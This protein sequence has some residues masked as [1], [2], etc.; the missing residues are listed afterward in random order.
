MEPEWL[1]KLASSSVDERRRRIE[2][3]HPAIPITR[4]CELLGLTR[5]SCYDR[6]EPKDDEN[7]RLM[8]LI[9]GTHLAH[10]A[11]GSRQMTRWLRR[12]RNR[13]TA[14]GCAG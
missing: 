5:A 1:K 9:D 10:P 8:K 11:F 2:Q 14:S 12:K 7:L 4:Q 6:P 13:S 3:K